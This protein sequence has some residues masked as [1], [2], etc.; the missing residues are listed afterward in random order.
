MKIGFF[1]DGYLPQRNGVATSVFHFAKEL[2]SL[3][4]EVYVVAPRYPGYYDH[5]SRT[6]RLTSVKVL[7]KP[8][9][10]VALHLPDRSLRR[11]LSIDFDIIHGHSGGPITLLG[12]EIAR[13]RNIPYIATHHTLWNKYTHYFLKGKVF[14]PK[15][16]ERA[17]KIFANRCTHIIAPSGKVR[18]ELLSYG[19]K[20]PISVIPSGVETGLFMEGKAYSGLDIP[21]GKI[22]LYVGRLG[23]EK[24]VDFLLK[25]FK[26]IR[27]QVQD[28]HLV[29]I[30]DGP[31]KNSLV[32]LAKKLDIA[33]FVHLLGE[34]HQE[35]VAEAYK[36]A[37]V[38][39]FASQ[40]ETQGMV[41]LE[42]LASGLPVIA[43]KD[44]AV[45]EV[46]KSAVNGFVVNKNVSEFSKKTIELLQNE[47]K[48]LEFGENA[49]VGAQDFDVKKTTLQLELLYKKLL[50][51]SL[52]ESV[53]RVM[54][55]QGLRE[56][57]FVATSFFWL[58]ILVVRI[59]SFLSNNKMPY[60][61]INFGS[62]SF[63]PLSLG[64]VLLSFSFLFSFVKKRDFL[65]P[66]LLAGA[67]LAG[68]ADEGW[69]FLFG[70]GAFRQNYWGLGNFIIILLLGALPT[71]FLKAIIRKDP[72]FKFLIRGKHVNT[73]FPRITVVVPAYNEAKFISA[74]LQALVNQ[75]VQDFELI[76]VDNN[77]ADDT[78]KVAESFGA[79]VIRETRP[80][81]AFARQAGFAAAKGEIIATTDADT[82]VPH[83]WLET[84]LLRLEKKSV[85][86]FGGLNRLY[87]GPVS[88]RAAGRYLFSPFWIADKYLSGGWNLMGS[89]MAVKSD[90]FH[91]IGGFNTSLTMGEDVDLA[92]RLRELG[93]IAIDT[94]FLV[95][96]S[97]RRFRHGVLLGVLVYLPSFV[98][99]VIFKKDKF[100]TFPTVRSEDS[101][102]SKLSLLPLATAIILLSTL[103]F[104]GKANP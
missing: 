81:V 93:E 62:F 71:L 66:V 99:R 21:E 35:E 90:A 89:N 43:V 26:N 87:S 69:G 73:E 96:S 61:Q 3:G 68:I 58:S 9:L 64:L 60:P 80:G 30:G 10:R 86:A 92:K 63:S 31:E 97:G 39:V 53:A 101:I 7:R 33:P 16:V 65:L 32:R 76:V 59:Y 78:G 100:L 36:R 88:A 42:A 20:A 44:S 79:K 74:T 45:L 11:V 8:E 15:M 83:D 48:R 75:T 72:K 98:A 28:S 70:Q 55:F 4:H 38:F 22:L 91:K 2:E 18:R 95:F 57:L 40:S 19:V 17:T 27:E 12:W 46:V 67:G 24:S 25:A 5:D 104:V 102:V 1:T 13:T 29:L 54:K 49:R 82:V 77:S 47:Q 103:F 51:K 23:K 37:Q 85:V 6:I 84:M 52:R 34:K 50:E 94:S 14:T 41:L 56:Q